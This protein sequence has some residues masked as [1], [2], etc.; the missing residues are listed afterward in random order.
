MKPR[1]AL[2]VSLVVL[3][4]S[5]IATGEVTKGMLQ[6]LADLAA[7][8]EGTWGRARVVSPFLY[9]LKTN[10]VADV[11]ALYPGYTDK[12]GDVAG[13]SAVCGYIEWVARTANRAVIVVYLPYVSYDSFDLLGQITVRVDGQPFT[14]VGIPAI[15]EVRART[16]DYTDCSCGSDEFTIYAVPMGPE[17]LNAVH[18][19][20]TVAVTITRDILGK[21]MPDAFTMTRSDALASYVQFLNGMVP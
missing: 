17:F 19:G 10:I 8:K 9:D 4:S 1:I 13:L 11:E 21:T 15:V 6:G 12:Y 3:C 5:G 2:A 20:M 7:V 16:I 14:P 18:A